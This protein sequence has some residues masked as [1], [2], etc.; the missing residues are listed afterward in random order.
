MD[1]HLTYKIA[2][3]CGMQLSSFFVDNVTEA[4]CKL[5][6]FI[7]ESLSDILHSLQCYFADSEEEY[8]IEC[9]RKQLRA[10]KAIKPTHKAPVYRII[11]KAR[12]RC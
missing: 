5:G 12:N 7:N 11:P 6:E 1:D 9:R 2:E 10:I 4:I 8:Q 3:V